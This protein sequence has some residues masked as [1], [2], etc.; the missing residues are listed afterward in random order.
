[1]APGLRRLRRDPGQEKKKDT[2]FIGGLYTGRESRGSG[3]GR[4]TIWPRGGRLGRK[5]TACKSMQFIEHFHSTP[6]PK[7]LYLATFI[8]PKLRAL[9]F[10]AHVPWAGTMAQM[11]LT[12]KE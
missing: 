10:T 2:S 3:V 9:I 6:F 12:D 4:R 5:A 1:M 7:N 11:L 8:Q